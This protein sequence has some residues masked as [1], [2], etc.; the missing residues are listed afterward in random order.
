MDT[1]LDLERNAYNAAFYELGLRWCWDE[2][3]W[4]DLRRIDGESSRIKTYLEKHQPHLLSVYDADFLADAISEAKSRCHQTLG[5]SAGQRIDWH[6][7]QAGEVG[8]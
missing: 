1:E 4:Q 7:L 6:A 2:D 3:T 5:R 8:C